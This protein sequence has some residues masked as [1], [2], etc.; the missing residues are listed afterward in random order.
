MTLS[1]RLLPLCTIFLLS[2][3][4]TAYTDGA[5]K[6]GVGLYSQNVGGE[7]TNKSDGSPATFGASSY[8]L[9]IKYDWKVNDQWFFTPQLSYTPLGRESA[10]GST[11]T[12]MA[13]L[14]LP[15]GTELTRSG[16]ILLDW[17]A[18]LGI[19]HYNIQGAGGT[20]TLS[21]GTGTSQFARPGRAVTARTVAVL[22]GFSASQE[23]LRFGLDLLFEG[24][25]SEKRTPSVMLSFAYQLN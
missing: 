10:G 8:P 16:P 19:I 9:F 7:V 23:S 5:F 3:E 22:L 1:L 15:V 11:S 18:G 17:Q 25:A 13:Q 20:E 21:N 6:L 4:A 14:L 2:I 24:L 12:T